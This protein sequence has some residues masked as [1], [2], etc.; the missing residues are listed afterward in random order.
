[1][2]FNSFEFIL[3]FLPIALA[4]YFLINRLTVARLYGLL[5]LA[6]AS[7]I[8]YSFWDIQF[9]PVLCISIIGNYTFSFWIGNNSVTIRSRKIIFI[10]AVICNLL[11]L[12]FYKYIN[13]G[14]D[15][16]NIL[17]SNKISPSAVILPLG[18]SFFTFT[19]IAYLADILSGHPK[20]KNLIKYILFVT[21]FPHLIAAV[22]F[23]II[24]K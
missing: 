23:F 5:Y 10:I 22:L 7:L 24:V 1:M 18:I 12:A 17:L 19:Q 13:F 20:E 3:M 8:F 4:G 9:L 15:I 6:I 21:Y 2:L 16:F 11:A 14:I